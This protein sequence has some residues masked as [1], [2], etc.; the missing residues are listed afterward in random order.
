MTTKPAPCCP[1]CAA[2]ASEIAALRAQVEAFQRSVLRLDES[3][4]E[5]MAAAASGR[6]A[7]TKR[8][9]GVGRTVLTVVRDGAA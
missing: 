9:A 4:G 5:A 3:T 2:N 6:R 8:P 1:S 7:R